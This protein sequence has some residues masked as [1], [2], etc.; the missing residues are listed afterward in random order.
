MRLKHELSAYRLMD[1]PEARQALWL[2]IQLNLARLPQLKG[3]G[4]V[5]D[6]NARSQAAHT[7]ANAVADQL[8]LSGVILLRGPPQAGHGAGYGMK[9]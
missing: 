6:P 2:A 5:I 1:D 7:L 9:D 4:R 8:A 3:K